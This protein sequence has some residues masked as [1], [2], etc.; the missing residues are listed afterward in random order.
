MIVRH[1]RIIPFPMKC[2][3]GEV[4]LL[5]FRSRYLYALWVFVIV[6]GAG[7][8]QSFGGGSGG[9]KIHNHL[10]T[11]QGPATPVLADE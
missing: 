7:D 1:Y 5:Q 8:A 9:N 10:M 3:T 2:I 6:H 4:N 11:Y